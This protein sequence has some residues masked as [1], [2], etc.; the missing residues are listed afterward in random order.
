MYKILRQ[1]EK[2]GLIHLLPRSKVQLR[3]KGEPK[4]KKGGPLSIAFRK[5]T[6]DQL[7]QESHPQNFIGV[8]QIHPKDRF[9]FE[10]KIKELKRFLQQSEA[11]ASLSEKAHPLT[12]AFL[13]IDKKPQFLTL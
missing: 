9:L 1:L 8:Y 6:L 11:R 12:I 3:V 7:I 5:A 4:W 2:L 13:R 10:E